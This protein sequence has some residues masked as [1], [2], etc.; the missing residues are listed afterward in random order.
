MAKIP[1]P[2]TTVE[3]IDESFKSDRD[4]GHRPHLGGSLIGHF[5]TRHIWYKFRWYKKESFNGR[6]YRLFERGHN[7][8]DMFANILR[9]AGVEVRH[10]KPEPQKRFFMFGGHFSCE[11]DG[12]GLGFFEAPKSEHVLEFK[13]YNHKS[14]LDLIGCSEKEY[15][16]LRDT[17]AF[18]V[19]TKT[20]NPRHYAQMQIGMHMSGL[21]RALYL[22]VNKNDD[23]LAQ[24]RLDYNADFAESLINKAESVVFGRIA[25]PRFSDIKSNWKCKTCV[26]REICH[27]DEEPEKNCRTCKHSVATRDGKWRCN[28]LDR[29]ISTEHQRGDYVCHVN[30]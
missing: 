18:L 9:K 23:C 11:I 10:A 27:N 17:Q 30:A 3:I 14:F 13:T 20:G 6:M 5:C 15:K 25:P 19:D 12:V 21:E 7:E 28:M 1:K 4:E 22:A 29:E 2:R 16:E 24:E 8:E 26:F